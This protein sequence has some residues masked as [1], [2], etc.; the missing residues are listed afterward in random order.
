MPSPSRDTVTAI[1]ALELAHAYL[2]DVAARLPKLLG[3]PELNAAALNDLSLASKE[4]A[5]AELHDIRDRLDHLDESVGGMKGY[6]KEIDD[7]HARM[8]AIEKHLGLDRKIAA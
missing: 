3:D 5:A 8:A 4:L 6:A 7:L 1:R 2:Q